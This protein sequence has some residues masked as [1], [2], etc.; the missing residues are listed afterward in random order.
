ML[1]TQEVS[2]YGVWCCLWVVG[3]VGWGL[4]LDDGAY[5]IGDCCAS[6]THIYTHIYTR[7]HIV[8]ASFSLA[9]TY[10]CMI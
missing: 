3:V 1:G 2:S 9:N 7:I 4:V 8:S 6:Y 10:L 5:V